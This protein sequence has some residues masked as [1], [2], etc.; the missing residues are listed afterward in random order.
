[1]VPWS[2]GLLALCYGVLATVWAAEGHRALLRSDAPLWAGLW[3]ALCAAA[4]AGLILLRPW[5]RVLA[6]VGAALLTVAL[7]VA[8]AAH[9]AAHQA[10]MAV[11]IAIGTVL[12]LM[13]MR[14]LSVPRVKRWFDQTQDSRPKT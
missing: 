8:S 3:C 13:V 5:G 14:Y 4:T 2:I 7:M 10:S 12:P 6:V 9:V 1:M 11:W